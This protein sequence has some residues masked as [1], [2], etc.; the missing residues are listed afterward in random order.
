MKRMGWLV[1][2]C[3]IA[4]L[5]QPARAEVVY[6][7]R[8]EL[9][10]F[11]L[12]QQAGTAVGEVL[13]ARQYTAHRQGSYAALDAL[14]AQQI[15]CGNC[16]DRDRLATEVNERQAAL[17]REDR[18]LCGAINSLGFGDAAVDAA[19][20]LTGH[21]R[22]C[23]A[24]S[25]E[26]G[27]AE[28]ERKNRE[29]KEEFARRVKAGDLDAYI[30]MGRRTMV[31][32][33]SLPIADRINLA[34]PY[35]YA[36][37]RKGIAAATVMFAEECLFATLAEVDMQD[38]FDE[39]RACSTREKGMCTSTLASYYETTRRSDAPWP[40]KADDREALRL[41]EELVRHYEKTGAAAQRI[42]ATRQR[43]AVV[44][45]R[46]SVP[47]SPATTAPQQDVPATAPALPQ[48]KAHEAEGSRVQP[49]EQVRQSRRDRTARRCEA[50]QRAVERALEGAG[51]DPRRYEPR[52]AAARA[53]HERECAK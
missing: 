1:I 5:G 8:S 15:S 20:K 23:E 11:A 26:A 21:A 53:N 28:A 32:D 29:N 41:Y 9:T 51:R 18:I 19:M 45:A 42:E 36:G 48:A 33:R 40:V 10:A 37:S 31:A 44:R 39:L 49:D 7:K 16:A 12:G 34:C 50:L 46:L 3:T 35:F 30:W 38:A 52:V 13:G 4:A 22:L 14:R 47:A 24:F 6:L 2:V 27:I 17:L 25:K 43:A